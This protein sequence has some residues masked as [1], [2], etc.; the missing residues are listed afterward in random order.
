[1]KY[2]RL[3]IIIMSNFLNI[4][5]RKNKII[6][7][8]I[9]VFLL[10]HSISF[11]E[12]TIRYKAE[13]KKGPDIPQGVFF[14]KEKRI[15]DMSEYKLPWLLVDVNGDKKIDATTRIRS[16]DFTKI[17]EV[18]DSNYDGKADDFAF[19]NQSGDMVYQEVDSNFDGKIDLWVFIRSGKY[20]KKF[21]RDKNFDGYIDIERKF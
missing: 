9:I 14:Y 19:F 12:K 10:I 16:R 6:F 1:M 3:R 17:V 13:D 15:W 4:I 20:V 7:L 8:S 2:L 11:A 18:L 5:C 21:Q